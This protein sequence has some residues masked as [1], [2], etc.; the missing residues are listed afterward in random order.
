MIGAVNQR[1]G[2]PADTIVHEQD[3]FN[4]EPPR[5]ALGR[6]AITSFERFYVRGHGVVPELPADATLRVEGLVDEPLELSFEQLRD[7]RFPQVEV[8]ATL[9]CAGNRRVELIAIRDIPGEASWGSGATGTAVWRG[10][11]LAD[12]IAAV[13]PR[14]EA[15]H[16]AFVG[17]E[18]AE[19]AKP[20]QRFG[21]SVPLEK[22]LRP[23]VVLAWEMNGE[24]LPSVHGGPLRAVVPGYIGARSVKWLHRVELRADPFDGYFQETA[25]R[26]IRPGEQPAPGLGIELGEILLNADILSADDAPPRPGSPLELRGYALAGGGRSVSRVDVSCDG[27]ETW[28][29]ARL[30]EDLGPWAWRLWSLRVELP[31]GEHQIFARAW[32][33]SGG[34]QPESPAT[35]WNP[36]GYMN[37]AWGRMRI[38]VAPAES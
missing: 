38:S 4:A 29:A 12:V 1:F 5:G 32:D 19:E 9:Q 20:P 36:K 7:G 17:A 23:E 37:T 18:R 33:T 10:V 8:T 11:R 14:P 34:T 13:G 30:L 26:L 21:G 3:P 6:E 31:P 27:G 2:K 25:Y 16:A 28:N 15:R 24:P 35:L 22:A